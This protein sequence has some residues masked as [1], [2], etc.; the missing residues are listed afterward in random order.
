M[1][2]VDAEGFALI[3]ELGLISS[4][5]GESDIKRVKEMM[6]AATEIPP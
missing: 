5:E 1:V 4:E 2:V 6:E 3:R